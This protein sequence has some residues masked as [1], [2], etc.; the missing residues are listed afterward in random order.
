MGTDTTPWDNVTLKF[1]LPPAAAGFEIDVRECAA[2]IERVA[3]NDRLHGAN[4][5]PSDACVNMLVV[6]A[7][8]RAG[9]EIHRLAAFN[10]ETLSSRCRPLV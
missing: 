8:D 4:L 9:T 6:A 5:A 1:A 10:Q 3:E 2:G 7:R